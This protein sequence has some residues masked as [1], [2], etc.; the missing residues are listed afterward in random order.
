MTWESK[1]KTDYGINSAEHFSE[2]LTPEAPEVVCRKIS[3]ET[4]IER[5]QSGAVWL[6]YI[7]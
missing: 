1:L 6:L 4:P 3:I 5:P 7:H 2:S